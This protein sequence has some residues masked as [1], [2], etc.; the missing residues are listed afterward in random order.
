MLIWLLILLWQAFWHIFK[1]PFFT[2]KNETS[3]VTS[4]W[5]NIANVL[6]INH[7]ITPQSIGY[8]ATQVHWHILIFFS[9]FLMFTLPPPPSLSFHSALHK[10]GSVNTTGF[11]TLYST[12][13]S[14][15]FL[16]M[17]RII[18]HRR[19]LMMFW[20]GRIGMSYQRYGTTETL[21]FW[22]F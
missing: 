18:Q 15:T 10:N 5:H 13:S 1:S 21:I 6:R 11:T 7:H 22:L 20:T 14:L 3:E 9:S 12:I 19:T 2:A 4:R 8:A 17:L 16:R